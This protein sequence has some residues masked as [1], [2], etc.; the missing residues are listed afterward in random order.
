MLLSIWCSDQAVKK[1]KTSQVTQKGDYEKY[2]QWL[3]I[4]K[5]MVIVKVAKA[6]KDK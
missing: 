3:K 4:L 5:E 2:W 6:F 1:V